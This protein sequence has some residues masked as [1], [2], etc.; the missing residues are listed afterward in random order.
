M[1]TLT[2]FQLNSQQKSNSI[3]LDAVTSISEPLSVND[4][5]I[6]EYCLQFL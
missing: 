1:T 5:G 3:R 4:T 6:S 2:F